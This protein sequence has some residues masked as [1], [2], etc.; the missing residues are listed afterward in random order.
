MPDNVERHKLKGS[1]ARQFDIRR[2]RNLLPEEKGRR[3]LRLATNLL[4]LLANE[5]LIARPEFDTNRQGFTDR[6]KLIHDDGKPIK[7]FAR[8][9]F[10]VAAEPEIKKRAKLGADRFATARISYANKPGPGHKLLRIMAEGLI[11][12]DP[13]TRKIDLIGK[14]FPVPGWSLKK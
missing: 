6:L 3:G 11:Q 13:P 10:D 2:L 8:D 4:F 7:D 14:R 12:Q 5:G 9:M 1:G